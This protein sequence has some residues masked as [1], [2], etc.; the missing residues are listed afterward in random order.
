M[1]KWKDLDPYPDPDADPG[2]PKAYGSDL[3]LDVDPDPEHCRQFCTNG[4]EKKEF[5]LSKYSI[6]VTR[7]DIL[8]QGVMACECPVCT[9]PACPSIISQRSDL[10]G[11]EGYLQCIHQ[12]G[13]S[14]VECMLPEDVR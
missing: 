7:D 2:G 4:S 8:L 14:V 13:Q 3:D 1:R 5:G 10:I 11:R 6:Y 12:F 9:C